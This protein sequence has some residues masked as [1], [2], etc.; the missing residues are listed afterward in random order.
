MPASNTNNFDTLIGVGGTLL[1]II[2]T[3][4]FNWLILKT[5][6]RHKRVFEA[7]SRR[8]AVYED[9][10]KEMTAMTDKLD[11]NEIQLLSVADMSNIITKGIFTLENLASRLLLYG[12]VEALAIINAL[13]DQISAILSHEINMLLQTPGTWAVVDVYILYIKHIETALKIFAAAMSAEIGG[14]ILNGKNRPNKKIVKFLDRLKGK[15]N[16]PGNN[17]NQNKN[18]PS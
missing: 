15:N 2:V 18:S 9:V 8:L 10:I 12:T 5:N 4:F 11:V 3:Q 7:Y 14:D 6:F 1:G 16:K 13:V 17:F